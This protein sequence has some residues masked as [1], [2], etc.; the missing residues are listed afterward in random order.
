MF[1][2]CPKYAIDMPLTCPK[3]V[4]N[5]TY[6]N[7]FH[8]IRWFPAHSSHVYIIVTIN[9]VEK[10]PYDFINPIKCIYIC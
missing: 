4:I 3:H 7:N 8:G 5:M 10:Q 6:I 1:N 2:I 9:S